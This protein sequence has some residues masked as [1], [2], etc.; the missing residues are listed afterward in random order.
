MSAS[1]STT[2]VSPLTAVPSTIAAV[3]LAALTFNLRQ[4]RQRLPPGCEILAVVKAD[5]YG[6][7]ALAITKALAQQGVARFGV[8]T[9]QEGAELR[10]AGIQAHVLVMGALPPS[11]FAD[12]L[13]YSLTPVIYD[14]AL[15]TDLAARLGTRP[16]PYPVHLKVDTGMGRLGLTS[17]QVLPLLQSP[18][19]RG[20]LRLEGLMTHLADADNSDPA[21]TRTQ[22]GRF[23]AILAQVKNAGLPVPLAH[24]ANSAAILGHPAAHF[25]AARPGIMLY[26]YSTA[27]QG[28]PAVPLKPIL[29][30]R[31]RIAQ[32]RS[33]ASG[34]SVSYNRFFIASRPSKVAVLPIGYADGYSRALSNR[35]QVLVQ[36]RR[37]P[38]VGRVCMDMT[39]VDVTDLP[40]VRPGDDAVLIGRQGEEEILA[41]DLAAWSG[42]IPYEVLC[43][44][45]PRVLRVY[46]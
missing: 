29:A 28:G 25:N 7:G 40:T 22:I 34:D 11:Q 12:L 17:E 44:I 15:A 6:H 1:V 13:D 31:S 19:F 41:T 39:L 8:A 45:G 9:I 35:G 2:S 27:P 36:G 16:T 3:D 4:A 33:L 5:A 21:Y 46:S 30:L 26:G 37:C 24:A 20:P 18:V 42:T 38:V 10:D 23:Q 14:P 43:G 32:V